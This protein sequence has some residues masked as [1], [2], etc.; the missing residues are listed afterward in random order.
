MFL[1]ASGR[2]RSG[3]TAPGGRL[4][5]PAP[6][7]SF[8]AVRPGSSAGR[9]TEVPASIPLSAVSPQS[10]TLGG[11]PDPAQGLFGRAVVLHLQHIANAITVNPITKRRGAHCERHDYLASII[12]AAA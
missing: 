1:S 10:G 8:E 6:A 11:N 4:W 12:G 2:A 7:A 5:N 9:A 3:V